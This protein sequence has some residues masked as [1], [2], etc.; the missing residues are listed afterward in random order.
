MRRPGQQRHRRPGLQIKDENLDKVDYSVVGTV[1]MANAG[2][3][4]DG[5]QFFIIYKDS[6]AGLGKDYTEIGTITTGMDIVQKVAAGRRD[7]RRRTAP[8]TAR[9]S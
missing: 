1:A 7:R 9:R 5:S 8:A 4:T 6:S 2:P 3:G